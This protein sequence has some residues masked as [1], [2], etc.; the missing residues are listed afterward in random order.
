MSEEKKFRTTEIDKKSEK[1]KK[2][3]E[4]FGKTSEPSAKKI[5]NSQK[6]SALS[7][8]KEKSPYDKKLVQTQFQEKQQNKFESL[9]Y[10]T[11]FEN[12]LRKKEVNF[13]KEQMTPSKTQR[14]FKTI[15]INDSIS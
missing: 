13:I 14:S 7:D 3:K 1:I 2:I 12:M 11:D 10:E 9:N 4:I 8:F 5:I 6:F 15:K